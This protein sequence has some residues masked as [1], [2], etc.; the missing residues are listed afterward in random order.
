M[1]NPPALAN[2]VV[3]VRPQAVPLAD[4]VFRSIALR[5]FSNF[6]AVRP[7]FASGGGGGG[8]RYVL[9]HGPSGLYLALDADT[10]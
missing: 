1:L 4:V 2:A 10:A 3:A 6:G 8:S 7:L 5:H 9:A